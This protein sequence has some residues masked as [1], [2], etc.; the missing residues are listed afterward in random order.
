MKQT[1]VQWLINTMQNSAG[2]EQLEIDDVLA[3]ALEMEKEQMLK[4]GIKCQ[5]DFIKSDG[6]RSV[7]DIYELT[8]NQETK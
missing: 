5:L 4:F 2:L 6:I 7:E 3:R 8:F 1:A